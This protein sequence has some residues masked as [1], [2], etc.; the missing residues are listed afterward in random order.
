LAR[1]RTASIGIVLA[2]LALGGAARAATITVTSLVDPGNG[3]GCALR[4]AITAANTEAVVNGCGERQRHH[5]VHSGLTGTITLT[6]TLPAIANTLT[7]EGPSGST[8]AITISGASQYE[9]MSVN[10]D[11]GTLNLAYLTIAAGNSAVDGGGIFN[12]GTANFKSTILAASVGGNCSGSITDEGYNISD[13]SSC[14]FSA[15]GTALN[16]DNVNPMLSRPRAGSTLH[17][18]PTGN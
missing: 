10:F 1:W 11:L 9:I 17:F 6:S 3:N 2:V 13:D 18:D 4:D 16:G 8:P 15:T 5:H 12:N 7:I 14:G